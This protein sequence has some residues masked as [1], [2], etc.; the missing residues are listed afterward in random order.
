VFLSN[1]KV[2]LDVAL[3]QV[4]VELGFAASLPGSIPDGSSAPAAPPPASSASNGSASSSS[5]DASASS[6]ASDPAGSSNSTSTSASTN[7]TGGPA[8]VS[9]PSINQIVHTIEK[10]LQHTPS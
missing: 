3:E 9:P 10:F 1:D 8:M 5:T 2:S 6:S 7:S 4:S